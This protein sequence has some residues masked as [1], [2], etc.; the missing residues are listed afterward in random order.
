MPFQTLL[1]SF[2]VMLALI[3]A[4]VWL[5]ERS[6]I[7][8]SEQAVFPR[9]VTDFVLPALI[10]TNLSRDPLTREKLLVALVFF[11]S[12]AIVTA[13]AWV[14]GRRMRLEKP[15]LGSFVLVSGVGSSSTLGYSLVQYV[16]GNNAQIMSMVVVMG[17]LGVVLPLFTVGV[18]IA[19]YFGSDNDEGA[20]IRSV[21]LTFVRSPI[22]LAFILGILVSLTGFPESHKAVVL[23]NIVLEIISDSLKLLVAFT[24]G[25][26]LRPIAIRQMAKLIVLVGV[27]KLVLEPVV[28]GTIAMAL[29]LPEIERSLLIIEAA[30]PSGALAAVIAARYGC[31]GA[32]ASTLLIGTFVLSLVAIPVVGYLI[33]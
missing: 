24:I 6:V 1:D 29:G 17:E 21:F 4:A 11:L 2:I 25:L 15:V 33:I 22:F 9:L 7:L 14:I 30:M 27:L 10:F 12:I 32:V 8:K 28:A 26:M 16:Y 20:D 19:S 23:F 18:A 5:R 3:G 31:D 13:A